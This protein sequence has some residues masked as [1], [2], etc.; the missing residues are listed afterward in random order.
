MRI[1]KKILLTCAAIVVVALLTAGAVLS[2]LYYTSI[3]QSTGAYTT[4]LVEQVAVNLETRTREYE[5]SLLSTV[6]TWQLFE[7]YFNNPD[8]DDYYNRKNLASFVNTRNTSQSPVREIYILDTDGEVTAFQAETQRFE[9]KSA[10]VE[11]F[12]LEEG[13]TVTKRAVW[14]TVDDVPD[15]A[16]MMRGVLNP[17][18]LKYQGVVVVGIAKSIIQEQFSTIEQSQQG[19]LLVLSEQEQLVFGDGDGLPAQGELLAVPPARYA[20][21]QL[22][23]FSQGRYLFRRADTRDDKWSVVFLVGEA[24]LFS[25]AGQMMYTIFGVC[26]LFILVALLLVSGITRKITQGIQRLILHLNATGAGKWEAIPPPFPKDEIGDITLAYNE[27]VVDLHS[28]VD[29]VAEQ[30]LEKEHAEYRALQAE[31]KELQAMINP[32][33]IYNAMESINA[34]AKLA[35]QERISALCTSLAKLMRA[36]LSRKTNVITMAAEMEYLRCYL[37]IQQFIMGGRLE[38]VFDLCEGLDQVEVPALLLQPLAENAIVHGVEGMTEGAVVYISVARET[39]ADED[40]LVVRISDNGTGMDEG[41]L[42]RQRTLSADSEDDPGH[43]GLA[44]V[45]RRIHIFYG[46]PYGL[47]V[48]STPGGGTNVTV[49][50]PA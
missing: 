46:P 49:T 22:T 33:F 40:R 25:A 1:G 5:D 13:D 8:S 18:S 39:R 17:T 38:V 31:F 4:M 29:E 2:R 16:Y 9:G 43:F 11:A 41:T 24:E 15:T 47:Q 27:M 6:Q 34:S 37:D 21:E 14:F 28:L 12:L 23:D 26:A 42:S 50:L 30:K 20:D 7:N 36:S 45:I 3:L 32:H 10:Q 35:G 44:S 19:H 48:D